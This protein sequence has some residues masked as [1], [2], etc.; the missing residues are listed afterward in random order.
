MNNVSIIRQR[1]QLTIPDSIRKQATWAR[2]DAVVEVSL[3]NNNEILVRPHA[4]KKAV[5]RQQLK[6]N[7]SAV[8][9]ANAK[10]GRTID[11]TQFII[12]DREHR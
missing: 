8:S 5:D 1:G 11:L 10:F 7:L 3:K 9:D 4:S 2:A 6:A 12:D